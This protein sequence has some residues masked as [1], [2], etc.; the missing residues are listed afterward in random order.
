MTDLITV[1]RAFGSTPG[2]PTWNPIADVDQNGR[3]DMTDVMV[4]LVNFGKYV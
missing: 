1:L 2:K 4:V 3:V